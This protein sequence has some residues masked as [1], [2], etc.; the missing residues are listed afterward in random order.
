MGSACSLFKE[1][2][3]GTGDDQTKKARGRNNR[4]CRLITF[5]AVRSYKNPHISTNTKDEIN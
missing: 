1:K 4:L 2:Q 3:S 5:Q